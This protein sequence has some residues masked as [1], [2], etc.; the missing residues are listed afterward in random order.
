MSICHWNGQTVLNTRFVNYEILG[1]G[2][3]YIKHPQHHLHTRNVCSFMNCPHRLGA[4]REMFESSGELEDHC[5]NIYGLEDL[6]LYVGNAHNDLFFIATNASHVKN[7]TSRIIRGIYDIEKN[8]CRN[9]CIIEPPTN[10]FCEKNWIPLPGYDRG[11]GDYD[12]FIYSWSPYQIGRIPQNVNITSASLE[13][14][15]NIENPTPR[16]DRVRGSTNFVE[17]QDGW[18]GVVHLSEEHYP[19]HYYHMMVWLDKETCIPK[20]YSRTFVFH[21][22]SIEFCMAFSVNRENNEDVYCF[23]ISNYDRDPEY[24]EVLSKYLNLD[25]SFFLDA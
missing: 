3:Y 19:R 24:M 20:K 18:L 10:T 15:V 23:W 11:E 1:N 5:N 6:R 8:L 21:K 22:Q 16:F 13:I 17:C 2:S 7:N 9:L 12:Y 25:Y 14:V 4:F